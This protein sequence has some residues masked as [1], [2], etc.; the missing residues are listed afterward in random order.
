VTGQ[1]EGKTALIT[2][3]GGGQG[4]AAAL[5]FASE[6]ARVVGCDVKVEGALETVEM[7]KGA[8]GEM[9]SMQ[10]VDLGDETAAKNWID[11]AV[12][13]YGDFDILYNN[14]SANRFGQVES[15]SLDDWNFT[16]R[17]EL[18]LVFLV[19]KYAVPVFRRRGAGV[20]VNA[21]SVVGTGR[22]V[23]APAGIS[24]AV[25]KAG[26]TVMGEYLANELAPL[27]V[28]VNTIAPGAINTP[29]VAALYADENNPIR[30]RQIDAQLIK[31]IGEPE[32]CA[33][34]ALYL[35][36]D[37]SS[38]MTGAE[39]IVDGGGSISGLCGNI[40]VDLIAN[41]GSEPDEGGTS[42]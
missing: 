36:S 31:R 5:L 28:R 39:L 26:V 41:D 32:D 33:K 34:A 11:F 23:Y 3:T 29:A 40:F 10:P 42:S 9:V 22:S 38:F 16:L 24:H 2:G 12:E 4:R 37:N 7:V 25:A 17:N 19:V 21:S 6:G 1:L 14:A 20:I 13:S 18:T 8:G 30:Q 35:A 15:L 27:N